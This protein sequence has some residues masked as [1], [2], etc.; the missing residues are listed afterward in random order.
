MHVVCILLVLNPQIVFW[1]GRALNLYNGICQSPAC[2]IDYRAQT[3]TS[4]DL[5][6]TE[7]VIIMRPTVLTLAVKS[8]RPVIMHTSRKHMACSGH[9]HYD[10]HQKNACD[11]CGTC[12]TVWSIF[13]PVSTNWLCL[14]DAQMPRCCDL[15]IFLV[16][17]K[18]AKFKT[19]PKFP[20]IRYTC[21]NFCWILEKNFHD[22][23]K[24]II[25]SCWS[26]I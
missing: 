17:T 19:S 25:Y 24:G 21:N 20:T 10:G 9:S 18:F 15:V 16:I 1:P 12:P 14:W 6:C 22:L 4:I 8:T 2:S 26:Y 3:P 5:H 13:K 23:V 7:M 11:A